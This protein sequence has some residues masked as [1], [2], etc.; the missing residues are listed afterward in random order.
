MENL[1]N[2]LLYLSMMA[3]SKVELWLV[4]R[5]KKKACSISLRNNF[6]TETAKSKRIENWI[7]DA[8]LHYVVDKENKNLLHISKDPDLSQKMNDLQ[9]SQKPSDIIFRGKQYNYPEKAVEA[10]AKNIESMSDY[11]EVRERI[12]KFPYWHYA[13]YRVRVRH[14]KDDLQ[15]AKKWADLIRKEVPKLAKW[16]EDSM[17]RIVVR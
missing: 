11:I 14:E 12:K 1:S 17:E 9:W 7:K 3:Q 8:G 4:H 13:R 10:F 2:R 5:D 16:F 6:S 15:V